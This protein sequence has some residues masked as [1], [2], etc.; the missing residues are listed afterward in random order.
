M[1]ILGYSGLEDEQ[2]YPFRENSDRMMQGFDSAAALISDGKI[3]ACAAEERFTGEKHTNRFPI[4]SISYCLREA[5]I[6]LEDI[7]YI[8]HYMDYDPYK[9]I[10]QHIDSLYFET[11]LSSKTQEKLWK[12]HYGSAFKSE[13]FIPV[14]HHLAHAASA[15]FPSGFRDALILVA[16][17]M[18]EAE[19]MSVYSAKDGKFSLL[20]KQSIENSMGILYSTITQHLGFTRYSDEYK[21][22]GLAPLGNPEK[23]RE[24][25]R[26]H[27]SF[28]EKG[29]Y[30][31]AYRKYNLSAKERFTQKGFLNYLD[32]NVIPK[33]SKDESLEQC[34]KDLAATVQENLEEVLFHVIRYWREKT[35]LTNLCYA[36]GVA[37]NC[38]FNG[39]LIASDLFNHVYIQPAAGDDGAALGAALY[40]YSQKNDDPWFPCEVPYYGPAY[41]KEEILESIRNRGAAV[42]CIDL[43]SI[44][45][46]AKYAAADIQKDLVIAL[47][48]GRMEYGPRALGNRSILANPTKSDI[49]S[50]LNRI[51]KKRE[52]FRPFA[53]AVIYEKFYQ[54]F[55]FH[56]SVLFDYM[57]ATAQV[58]SEWRSRLPGVTHVDGSARVQTVY[59]DSNP[60]FYKIIE[61]FG[62]LSG[63]YTVVNTSFNVKDQ[64]IILSPEV[65][66]DTFLSSAIDVLYMETVRITKKPDVSKVPD[67]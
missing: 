3:I 21:V 38:T 6:D 56:D 5:G 16:D 22:M 45:D 12:K 59:R 36:G 33:R 42:E 66:L 62:K 32:H 11:V 27:T 31:L 4:Q 20:A 15:Y 2:G 46:T 50:R 17:G 40:V 1:F 60:L 53:P 23:F 7:N 65:A 14:G 8:A 57:L 13:K 29:K 43:L 25:F 51:V 67:K 30:S 34:H 35:G 18:G 52:E 54:M 48:Q 26:S 9:E 64:P 39:K 63:V 61:E 47:F 37:L 24:F 41:R 55:E 49:Q 28:L 44:D 10:F 19:S 58:R